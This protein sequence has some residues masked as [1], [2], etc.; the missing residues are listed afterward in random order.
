MSNISRLISCFLIINLF[1][2]LVF[3]VCATD[4]KE[5][6][7][8]IQEQLKIEKE[9]LAKTK[10]KERETLLR[11][12]KT[13]QDLEITKKNLKKTQK[14]LTYNQSQISSISVEIDQTQKNIRKK[15]I[16]LSSKIQEIYKGNRTSFLEILF[17]SSSMSDFLIRSYYFGKVL[18]KDSRIIN[19]ILGDYHAFRRKKV[20]LEKTVDQIEQQ[21]NTIK[22]DREFISD[23]EKAEQ[24]L[25]GLLKTRREEYEKKVKELEKVSQE[26]EAFIQKQQS[27]S[28]G[29]AR[30]KGTGNFIWPLIGRHTSSFGWRRH[31]L[32]RSRDFHTGQDIAAPYGSPIVAA[33][34][35][36]VIFAGWRG[37][38]GK[39]VIISHGTTYSTVYGHMSRL[40]VRTG[41]IITKGKSVGLVGSTGWS[42]GPHLHFEIRVNG[43]PVNPMEYLP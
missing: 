2:F 31:P 42:T 26:L 34:S 17:S 20:V 6:F 16:T 22:K 40:Y 15:S 19:E 9:R 4:E 36:E 14:E 13:R 43:K 18:E 35:G 10:E 23:Q 28:Q 25:Y 8:K 32:W 30:A 33:D 5:D 37:A 3:T 29:Q 27:Q 7:E 39:C 1:F 41:D 38:Y 11:L 24:Q 21:F 12:A